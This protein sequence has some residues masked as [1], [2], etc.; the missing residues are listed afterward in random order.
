MAEL[1]S[2]LSRSL[3]TASRYHLRQLP[4]VSRTFSCVRQHGPL[5]LVTS[6]P[7]RMVGL[8][9]SPRRFSSASVSEEQKDIL[10]LLSEII[11]PDLHR[12][13]VSL[14][15]VKNMQID[16]D[17][18]VVKFDLEL[19]TPACPVKDQ[20]VSACEQI[21]TQ[22]LSWVK[23]VK[24]SLT[25]QKGRR[26]VEAKGPNGLTR[27]ANIV[28]VASCKGG[29]TIYHRVEIMHLI[30]VLGTTLLQLFLMF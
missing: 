3:R 7:S 4:I 21:L 1:R 12:D 19:T 2:I 29:R 18:G 26:P 17:Q 30:F 22:N 13:I 16:R 24:V 27:V 11:D 14:G 20:F 8:A 9:L 6:G 5:S 28:A 10:R 15:F 23:K 25:A